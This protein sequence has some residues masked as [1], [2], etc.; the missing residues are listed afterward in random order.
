MSTFQFQS[1]ANIING[2]DSLQQLGTECKRLNI[3]RVLLVTDQGILQ[4][5]L[6]QPILQQLQQDDIDV[7]IY[8]DVQADPPEQIVE[9]AVEFAKQQHID[10]VI[11]LGGGSSL[12][13]A[14]LIA[15]VVL[16]TPPF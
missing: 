14:K 2:I 10:G 13:V 9:L 3:Q 11:G 12:D 4:Q 16:P 6:Q 8:A 7:I 5:H 1:V 15:V